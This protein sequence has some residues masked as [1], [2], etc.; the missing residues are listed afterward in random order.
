MDP[1]VVGPHPCPRRPILDE[2]KARA[3][4][5]SSDEARI[6]GG[7]GR[8][9]AVVAGSA[10]GSSLAAGRDP[11]QAMTDVTSATLARPGTSLGIDRGVHDHHR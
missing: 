8:H 10:W 5:E 6:G 7:G 1:H 9:G 11:R 2:V 3:G 4:A